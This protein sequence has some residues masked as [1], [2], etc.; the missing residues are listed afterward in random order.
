MTRLPSFTPLALAAVLAGLT[1]CST[2]K[3]WERGHLARPVMDPERDSL[4]VAV[5]EHL[6]F[7]R[8][9][10]HGGRGVGGGGCGCN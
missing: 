6:Y 7:S 1:S 5:A 3:P 10:S 4:G 2:V 8:E 9:A